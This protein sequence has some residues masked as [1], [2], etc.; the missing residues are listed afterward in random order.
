[1]KTSEVWSRIE[2][3]LQKERA[4]QATCKKSPAEIEAYLVGYEQGMQALLRNMIDAGVI[5]DSSQ[6]EFDARMEAD[7]ERHLRIGRSFDKMDRKLERS[8][9]KPL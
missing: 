6:K 7:A 3:L 9:R 4:W 1:M 8:M 2:V 5:D